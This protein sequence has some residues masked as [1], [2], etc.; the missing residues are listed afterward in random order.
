MKRNVKVAFKV[1][2]CCVPGECSHTLCTWWSRRI[3][4]SFRKSVVQFQGQETRGR[5]WWMQSWNCR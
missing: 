1:S 3:S 2:Q 5:N 4:V